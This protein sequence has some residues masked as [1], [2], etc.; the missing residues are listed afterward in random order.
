MIDF[1]SFAV[2]FAAVVME[3]DR[4]ALPY[5]TKMRSVIGKNFGIVRTV[6]G[7]GIFYGVAATL[8]LSES[9]RRSKVIGTLVLLVGVAYIVLG[10]MA[11]N[12]MMKIR[13]QNFPDKKIK[14]MF[15]NYDKNDNDRIEFDEFKRML[16][17]LKLQL[18]YQ[19]AE[20][21]Y[22]SIDKDMNHGLTLAEFQTFW[23]T[24][25]ELDTFT[26]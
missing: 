9:N 22:L 8:E 25:A 5:A 4:E 11:H 6:T 20:V 2:G 3:S 21:L 15:G 14:Q 19:E 18:N 12:K 17:D 26:I 13:N 7:R 10:R 1:Y 23:S 16:E 24:S